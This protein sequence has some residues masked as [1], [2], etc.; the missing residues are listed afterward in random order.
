MSRTHGDF[1]TQS[2]HD[3]SLFL[4]IES[5]YMSDF[6]PKK[7]SGRNY[8]VRIVFNDLGKS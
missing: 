8:R 3:K 6:G 5:E 4:E 7:L 1:L 2:C